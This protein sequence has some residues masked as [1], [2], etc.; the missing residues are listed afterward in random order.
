MLISASDVDASSLRS[1]LGSFASGVTVL[2]MRDEFSQPIGM[3]ATAFSSLSLDG[4]TVLVCVNRSA[5][6]HNNIAH[7][8]RFGV[9]ILETENLEIA[10]HCSKPNSDKT[11]DP[12]WLD[13]SV[14]WGS[15]A[16]RTALAFLDC[17]VQQE[18][19]AVSHSIFIGEVEGL[20][21]N[22]D[23]SA[24]PLLFFRGKFRYLL[25]AA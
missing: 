7:T 16:L 23:L 22:Q 20:A 18:I 14:E 12:A 25:P 5:R 11:L 4:R 8:G 9:N 24:D 21:L 17:R 6:T 1:V 13:E 10:R 19:A 2:T 3:T 15:P